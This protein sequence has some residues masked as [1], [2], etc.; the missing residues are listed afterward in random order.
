MVRI[1]G[2]VWEGDNGFVNLYSIDHFA[3]RRK[4]TQALMTPLQY[5]FEDPNKLWEDEELGIQP[6]PMVSSSSSSTPPK[7]RQ[8]DNGSIEHGGDDS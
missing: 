6:F 1:W 7:P 5:N 4:D 8:E 2:W 3:P